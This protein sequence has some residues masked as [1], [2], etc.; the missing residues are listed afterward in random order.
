MMQV[1]SAQPNIG[2]LNCSWQM[3]T[4]YPFLLGIYPLMR[5]TYFHKSNC[6]SLEIT[7]QSI[8][9]N[10]T[11]SFHRAATTSIQLPHSSEP[12]LF[13]S[14]SSG[15]N[16]SLQTQ[17]AQIFGQ[18]KKEELC[19]SQPHV[20]ATQR[21]WLWFVRHCICNRTGLWDL[22]QLVSVQ[23]RITSCYALSI[24]KWNFSMC[25]KTSYNLHVYY[26]NSAFASV[27]KLPVLTSSFVH[28]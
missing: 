1:L 17:F 9:I 14:K 25:Q 27:A 3:K 12:K 23:W 22:I 20:T 19:G 21:G 5:I 10:N 16:S 15:S 11:G 13:Y 6:M 4:K 28:F 18:I 24:R 7:S 8:Q 2:F 26:L